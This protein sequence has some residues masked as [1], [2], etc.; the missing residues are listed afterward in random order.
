MKKYSIPVAA[1]IFV[2]IGLLCVGY[3]TVKLGKASFG[4][5]NVFTLYARFSTVSG[6]KIGS[7]VDIYGIEVGRVAALTID[8][9]GQMAV[10]RMDISKGTKFYDDAS[11]TVKSSGVLGDK[12]VK[13]DPGGSGKALKPGDFIAKTSVPADIEDVIGKFAFGDVNKPGKAP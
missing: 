13:I 4:R 1:A 11:A 6:L 7:I 3:M 8:T 5:K 9:D 10:V 12:Y 2:M